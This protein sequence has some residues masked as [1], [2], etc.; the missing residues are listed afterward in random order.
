[1]HIANYSFT[2]YF[3]DNATNI[4]V[5]QLQ[6]CISTWVTEYMVCFAD[7]DLFVTI[8]YWWLVLYMQINQ[9]YR[10]SLRIFSYF[11]LI[12]LWLIGANRGISRLIVD[13]CDTIFDSWSRVGAYRVNTC[14]DHTFTYLVFALVL[15][16]C[17]DFYIT[18]LHYKINLW[19]AKY[20]NVLR[21]NTSFS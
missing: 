13:K 11:Y 6:N 5:M 15:L 8:T 14:Y 12:N 3:V 4:F 9:S 16:G 7:R 2:K 21:W 17:R 18:L 1:M 19:Y 20:K 10:F